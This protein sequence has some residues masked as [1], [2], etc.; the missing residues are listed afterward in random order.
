MRLLAM[1][2][3]V[4]VG[5]GAPKLQSGAECYDWAGRKLGDCADGLMCCGC[6]D[7]GTLDVPFYC[8]PQGK[9]CP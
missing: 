1:L 6:Y 7:A 5:C 3:L 2:F 9:C 8:V 4:G